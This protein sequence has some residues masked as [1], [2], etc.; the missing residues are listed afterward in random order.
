MRLRAI[1]NSLKGH[2]MRLGTAYSIPITTTSSTNARV[3][4][5]GVLEVRVASTADCYIIIGT[6]PVATV[7]AGSLLRP[8]VVG[9]VFSIAAGEQVAVVGAA[10]G[11]TLN[12]T[13]MTY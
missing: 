6:G 5:T 3:T 9:E 7:A 8:A 4:P 10:A 12:I 11:G 13:E 2:P 1:L